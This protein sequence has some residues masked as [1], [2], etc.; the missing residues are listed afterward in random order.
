MG[1][2]HEI[3]ADALPALTLALAPLGVPGVVNGVTELDE[4]EYAP[5]PTPFEAATM[6]VY[7]I[8]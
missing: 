3:V 2:V 7:G 8:W 4:E 1:A 6:K 5:V